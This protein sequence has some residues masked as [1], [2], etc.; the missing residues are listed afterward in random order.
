MKKYILIFLFSII[1]LITIFTLHRICYTENIPYFNFKRKFSNVKL[2]LKNSKDLE[3]NYIKIIGNIDSSIFLY[4]DDLVR[5]A[6]INFDTKIR[7]TLIKSK[8]PIQTANIFD[9]KLY[10]FT[11]RSNVYSIFDNSLKFLKTDS[12]HCKFDRGAFFQNLFYYRYTNSKSIGQFM[13]AN[14]NGKTKEAHYNV[15][16]STIVDG[17]I[18]TD[19]YFINNNKSLL[20]VEYHKGLFYKLDSNK[21]RGFKMP[22]TFDKING[23]STV[24]N[25]FLIDR[26]IIAKNIF[27]SLDGDLLYN[28]SFVKSSNQ[29]LKEF[30][31]E[32]IVD[33]YDINKGK[34]LH[35]FY[36]PNKSHRKPQDILIRSKKLY[37]LYGK[38]IAK[39]EFL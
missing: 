36:L 24:G 20:Y 1:P 31:N 26:P 15:S 33:V 16:D 4:T 3:N 13:F 21:I 30:T 32:V 22:Y 8:Y 10:T 37:V 5:I 6:K 34:Y 29:T 35:S 19:G 25:T 18:T 2:V 14:K 9:N 28:A 17:G 11:I 12:T 27:S 39:Y 38:S 7:D 23:F